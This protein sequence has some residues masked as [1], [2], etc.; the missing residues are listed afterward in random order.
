MLAGRDLTWAEIDRGGEVAIISENTARDLWGDPTAALGR[1]IRTNKKD[2]WREVIGVVADEHADGVDK[3][4]PA[5]VYW[6]LLTR[7]FEGAPVD[8]QRYVSF[9]IRTPRAGSVSLER[10]IRNALW[11][12]NSNLPLARTETIET[13]YKRSLAR[14]SFTLLLLAIAGSVAL[15]LGIV[16]IYGVISYS[17]SQRTREIGIRLALGAPIPGSQPHSSAMDW[18]CQPSVA[19][20][21]WP[22]RFCSCP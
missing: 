18:F 3:P 19:A 22:R 8:V 1:H 7:N 11:S 12:V 9:V 15:L 21:G 14:T 16:G 4:A 10:E 5:I 20:A 13:F 2:D 17:V 6:P